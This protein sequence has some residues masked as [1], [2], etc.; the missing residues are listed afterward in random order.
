MKRKLRGNLVSAIDKSNSS[1][2]D[3]YIIFKVSNY[4]NVVL[5]KFLEGG[6][7]NG[8]LLCHKL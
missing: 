3:N 5:C 8:Q 4:A 7:I 2:K 1:R 6:E